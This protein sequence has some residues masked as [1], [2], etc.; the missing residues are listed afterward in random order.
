MSLYSC[1]RNDLT[2]IHVLLPDR[3]ELYV[4]LFDIFLQRKS[5]AKEIFDQY[6]SVRGSNSVNIDSTARKQAEVQLDNPTP[7]MF[8]V[9]QAQVS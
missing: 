1:F 4:L 8:E 5:K 9:A 6:V 7:Q 3:C 2:Q